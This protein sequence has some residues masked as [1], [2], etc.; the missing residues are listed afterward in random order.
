MT[1]PETTPR[2]DKWPASNGLGQIERVV[3][4]Y[5][6]PTRAFADIRRS[7]S[8]W[9]PFLLTVVMGYL[10]TFAIQHEIGFE[11]LAETTLQNNAQMQQRTS[12]MTPDQVQQMNASV[13]TS[14]KVALYAAPVLTLIF[15]LVAAGILMMSFNL[16]LG[17]Q[18]PFPHYFAVWMYATLPLLFKSLL[19]SI[20]LFAGLGADQFQ[21]ENPV[22]TNIGFYLGQDAPKW[23]STLLSSADIFTLW[24]VALLV[25]GCATV[26]K[27][28]RGQAAMVVVGWWVLAVLAS[29][30]MA[31][32]RG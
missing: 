22:G 9:L 14:Y 1:E 27:V 16:G 13:A 30:A 15:A 25:I 10:F 7:A 8:W 11:K 24:T 3:D 21:L 17:A 26:T 6:A 4:A 5:V 12:S 28:K 29:T 20:T 2:S 18:T 23:L 19:A 31:A 32:I